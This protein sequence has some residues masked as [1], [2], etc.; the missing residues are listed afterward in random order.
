MAVTACLEPPVTAKACAI[1]KGCAGVD[2]LNQIVAKH[3]RSGFGLGEEC[4]VPRAP[5]K[6]FADTP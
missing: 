4:W 1:V 6:G 3:G 2:L 5:Q